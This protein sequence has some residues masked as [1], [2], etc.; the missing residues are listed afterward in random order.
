MQCSRRWA[1]VLALHSLGLPL[2]Q[3]TGRSKIFP[4]EAAASGF[5]LMCV[6]VERALERWQ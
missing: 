3:G 1:S 2:A 6:P 4:D 5:L